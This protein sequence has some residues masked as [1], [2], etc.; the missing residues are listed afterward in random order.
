MKSLFRKLHLWLSVPFGILVTLIC[1]SGAML[2]FEKELTEWSNPDL[3]RTVQRKGDALPLPELMAKAREYARRDSL[4]L[5]GVTIPADPDRA[6]AIGLSG[7][8]RRSLMMDQYTGEVKGIAS[9]PAFFQ[10]MHLMHG[11]LF[12]KHKYEEGETEWGSLLVGI[13]TAVL[14]IV[15]LTGIVLWWPVR[16]RSLGRALSIRTGKGGFRFLFSLH[17]AGGMYALLFLLAMGI[18]GL[19]WAFPGFSKGFYSL[20]GAPAEETAKAVSAPARA[21]DVRI[22]DSVK[23]AAWQKAYSEVKD[24]CPGETLNVSDKGVSVPVSRFGNGNAKDLYRFDAVSGKIDGVERYSSQSRHDKASQTVAS[25][26]TGTWGGLAT[27]IIYL[28]AA[29]LGAL[30]PITGYYLWLH[31]LFIGKLH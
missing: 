12:D 23:Y 1:F 3:Y 4:E 21:E 5:T 31:R 30:L 8:G 25:F 11:R 16:G 19:T 9:R 2:V 15:L 6:Y 22:E 24:Y 28:L 14:V 10:T 20:I 13:S 17:D 18:S 7:R 27:R 29:L 26:H